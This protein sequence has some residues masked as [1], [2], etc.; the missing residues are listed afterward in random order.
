[1][2]SDLALL[3]EDNDKL[4]SELKTERTQLK[5]LIELQIGYEDELSEHWAE[6]LKQVEGENT[7]RRQSDFSI[8]S[9]SLLI[10]SIKP[11]RLNRT[12]SG[13]LDKFY[14]N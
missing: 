4:R 14:S 3:A 7:S 1:M 12:N 8:L 6:I 10:S 9:E 13:S 5:E 2:R 11:S